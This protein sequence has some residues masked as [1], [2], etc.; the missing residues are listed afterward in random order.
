MG[1]VQPLRLGG[2]G[3]Y[4]GPMATEHE[5]DPRAALRARLE[6]GEVSAA[7]AQRLLAELDRP[8]DLEALRAAERPGSMT[9]EQTEQVVAGWGIDGEIA[10]AMDRLGLEPARR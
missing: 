2:A 6:A 9:P 10:A 5:S 1:G 3:A 8:G 4:T 7:D